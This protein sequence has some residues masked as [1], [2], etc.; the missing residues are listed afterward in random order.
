MKE[1]TKILPLVTV[2]FDNTKGSTVAIASKVKGGA[3]IR[4]FKGTPTIEEI[5][6]KI[7]PFWEA[8]YSPFFQDWRKG[9]EKLC[10]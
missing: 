1:K 8:E 7:S 10:A 9:L 6:M 3:A 5:E 2:S 4:H